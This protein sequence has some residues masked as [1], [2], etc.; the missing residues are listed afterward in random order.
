MDSIGNSLF[1]IA[2]VSIVFTPIDFHS[3]FLGLGTTIKLN[4]SRM[5]ILLHPMHFSKISG[6]TKF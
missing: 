6:L 1:T 5:Y 3:K 4:S 2:I